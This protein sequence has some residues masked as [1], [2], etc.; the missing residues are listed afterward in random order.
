MKHLIPI[1]FVLAIFSC[2]PMT[3]KHEANIAIVKEYVKTVE[4]MDFNGMEELL[5]DNY[6]G[7]GPSDNDSMSKHQALENWKEHRENL[8]ESIEYVRTQYQELS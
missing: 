2:N 6:M 7:Y 5:A 1:L 8:Y 4:N 3:S